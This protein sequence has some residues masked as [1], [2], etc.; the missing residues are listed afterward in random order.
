MNH[1]IEM[2]YENNLTCL[3]LEFTCK[4]N[5]NQQVQPLD[6]HLIPGLDTQVLS[7]NIN[8]LTKP[9]KQEIGVLKKQNICNLIEYLLEL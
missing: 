6:G 8:I 9:T 3:R 7:G 5:V 2:M 1:A 4:E